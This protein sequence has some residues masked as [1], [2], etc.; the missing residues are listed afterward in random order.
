VRVLVTDKKTNISTLR[1]QVLSQRL[2]PGQ[3]EAAMVSLQ[4]LNP[5]VDLANVAPG[6]VLFVPDTPDF[7]P[8]GSDSVFDDVLQDFERL[9]KSSLDAATSR[10]KAAS[11]STAAD[12]AEVAKTFK[13][14]AFKR[15]LAQDAELQSAVDDA[16]AALK[17]EK[18]ARDQAAATLAEATKG[19]VAALHDLSGN[20]RAK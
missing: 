10:A 19:A 11:E 9:V 3:A 5:H 4:T 15:V 12:S 13:S 17:D 20:L 16:N 8:T 7:Q 14:A 2:N 18:Q 1:D 6:T